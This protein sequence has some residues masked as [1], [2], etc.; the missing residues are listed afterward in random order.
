MRLVL[1]KMFCVFYS[2]TNRVNEGT[3]SS[4]LKRVRAVSCFRGTELLSPG[5]PVNF[6]GQPRVCEATAGFLEFA[7]DKFKI[8]VIGAK[9][10]QPSVSY[11][12]ERCFGGN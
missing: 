10:P 2:R 6:P 12:A 1:A 9:E 5:D 7:V 8:W 4:W 11:V 3:D